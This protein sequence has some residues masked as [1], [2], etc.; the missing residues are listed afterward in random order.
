MLLKEEREKKVM[1]G[2]NGHG[3]GERPW[4]NSVKV[5]VKGGEREG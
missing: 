3:V 4:G 2:S 1:R 5:G